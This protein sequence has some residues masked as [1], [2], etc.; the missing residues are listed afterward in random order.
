MRGTRQRRCGVCCS[1]NKL[2][3]T[4]EQNQ[5]LLTK[6][7]DGQHFIVRG[8][9]GAKLDCMFFPCTVEDKPDFLKN[10]R[11]AYLDK[12]TFIMCNPNALLY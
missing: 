6:N 4:I 12:P 3:G 1:Y 9:N 7:F 8:H 11:G 2:F 5:L 10:P